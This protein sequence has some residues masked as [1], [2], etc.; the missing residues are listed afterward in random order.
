MSA[1]RDAYGAHLTAATAR[2]DALKRVWLDRRDRRQRERIRA[3]SAEVVKLSRKQ[4]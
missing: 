3:A 2:A 1:R 4:A